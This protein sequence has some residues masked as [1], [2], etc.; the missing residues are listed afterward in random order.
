MRDPRVGEPGEDPRR[1]LDPGQGGRDLPDR[2]PERRRAADRRGLRGGP[3]GRRPPGRRD[4]VRRASSRLLRARLRRPARVDL[5]ARSSG[6]PRRPTAGS[7]S[8]PTRTRARSLRVPP[9]RQTKRQAATRPLMESTMKRSAEGTHRWVY[10]L[11]PTNAYASDAEMSLTA[12]ED[13]YFGACLADYGDP[14]EDWKQAS[15]ETRRLAERVNGH[16]EVH[17]TGAGHG[18]PARRRGPHVHP[19]LRRPQHARRRVLHRAGRGLGRGRGLVP[20]AGDGRRPRGRRASASASRP[21]RSSTPRPSA[22]RSS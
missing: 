9:E 18:H 17:I 7:R 12:F 11:F 21:A 5:A 14:L 3:G 13:F 6:P 4:V 2:G 16:S 10:T 15:E 20:P 19:L 22:A 1:L 8:A